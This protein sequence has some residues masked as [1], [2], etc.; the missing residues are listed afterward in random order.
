MRLLGEVEVAQQTHCA[1][2]DRQA[3]Q[4][5]VAQVQGVQRREVLEQAAMGLPDAALA[6]VQERHMFK[7][8]GQRG[9]RF[10]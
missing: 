6:Q 9:Q 7:V 1:K 2:L 5:V 3:G 8:D 4:V 10:G